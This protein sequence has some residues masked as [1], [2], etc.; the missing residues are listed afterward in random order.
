MIT[1][2]EL[3]LEFNPFKD[4][5]A[6]NANNNLVWASMEDVKSKLERS[7]NDCLVNNSKQIILNWGQWGG[8][9][10]FS[11]FYFSK[12][13]NNVDHL[14]HIYV[15]CPKDG[16]KAT[17]E[18]FSSVIDS[19]SFDKL[20]NHIRNLIAQVGEDTLINYLSPIAT[21]EFAKAIVLIGSQNDEI[22]NTMNRFLFSG[23]TKT[24][25]KKLGLS[26]DIQTD[27]DSV[28][29]LSGI[30][31]CYTGTDSL[32]NGRVVI[33]LDEMEDLIYFAP[34]NYKIFSQILRDLF[35]AIPD[36]FLFFMNFTLAEGQESTIQLILGDALWSRV[37]KKIRY[38]EFNEDDALSYVND[39]LKAAKIDKDSAHPFD[40]DIARALINNI[41]LNILTPR[42]INKHITSLLSYSLEHE[43]SDI[44][45]HVLNEWVKDYAEE[46][47]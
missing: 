44:D 19:I 37:T 38:K 40:M 23:I 32:N 47:Q 3:N 35:D 4:A 11:A 28:K 15:K 34:K 21:K 14:Q 18:F 9:K 24:E 5:T 39:L 20:S 26:R 12:E 43:L 6:N 7:Y 33:W 8:G 45:V 1:L 2:A 22:C 41:P 29:F 42:E 16:T 25:L 17:D 46:S 36:R 31:S 27:S 10:T 13:M 30:L